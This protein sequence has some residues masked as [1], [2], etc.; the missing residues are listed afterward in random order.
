MDADSFRLAGESCGCCLV[1]VVLWI[2]LKS[3]R[4]ASADSR[5]AAAGIAMLLLPV[6]AVVTRMSL[7]SPKDINSLIVPPLKTA[8]AASP[9]SEI[10]VK[11]EAPIARPIGEIAP[12]SNSPAKAKLIAPKETEPEKN[13][14]WLPWIVAIWALGVAVEGAE[15]SHVF[16]PCRA[17]DRRGGSR[18]VFGHTAP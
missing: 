7:W 10:F 5:H 12:V 2:A 1:A 4:N 13:R 17:S 11:N 6:C 8:L 9:A 16:V 3:L 14:S 15:L 18:Q